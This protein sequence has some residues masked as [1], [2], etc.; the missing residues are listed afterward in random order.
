VGKDELTEL[1]AVNEQFA[2]AD[3]L[4][5]TDDEKLHRKSFDS[6]PAGVRLQP[7]ALAF[8][9]QASGTAGQAAVSEIDFEEIVVDA[10]GNV[11]RKTKPK[12]LGPL[13]LTFAVAFGPAA[14]SQLRAS[15]AERFA[16]PGPAFRVGQERFTVAKT[17]DL[18]PVDIVGMDGRSEAAVR[19]ALERHLR[20]NPE[21]R[22]ALQVVPAFR[23]EVPA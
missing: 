6:M 15:G 11:V 8:G 5:L 18:D 14:Q 23:A 19:Q 1:P 2:A 9:G 17:D 13:V 21:D 7:K 20:E 16:A 10:D 4:E 12:T 3:F 22:G